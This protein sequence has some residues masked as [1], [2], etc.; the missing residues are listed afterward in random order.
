MRHNQSANHSISCHGTP[1]TPHVLLYDPHQSSTPYHTYPS[2]NHNHRHILSDQKNRD[3]LQ[4][5]PPV[6]KECK[7]SYD[8]LGMDQIHP[9]YQQSVSTNNE[10]TPKTEKTI[11]SE[12]TPERG[13][14]YEAIE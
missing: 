12:L 4:K 10:D 11:R 9:Q 2:R 6:E 3:S 14:T 8:V 5:V 13:T 7:H 1:P